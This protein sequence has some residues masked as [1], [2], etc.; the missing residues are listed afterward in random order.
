MPVGKGEHL[1]SF[2]LQSIQL[3]K[4]DT[5]YLYTDGYADQFGGPKGKKFKY[6]S[7][8]QLLLSNVDNSMPRQKE[9]LDSTIS[10]WQG[11]LEQIDDVCVLGI[12]I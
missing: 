1:N 12:R 8:N 6:K 10:N 4:G 11:N 9:V 5:L 3:E 2:T 7:L